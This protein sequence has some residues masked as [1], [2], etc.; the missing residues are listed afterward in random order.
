MEGENSMNLE[1]AM[2]NIKDLKRKE[3]EKLGKLVENKQV[4]E[5]KKLTELRHVD[6]KVI[7]KGYDFKELKKDIQETLIKRQN[8]RKGRKSTINKDEIKKQAVMD[9]ASETEKNIKEQTIIGAPAVS[10]SM[11]GSIHKNNYLYDGEIDDTASEFFPKLSDKIELNDSNGYYSKMELRARFYS[12]WGINYEEKILSILKNETNYRE[13]EKADKREILLKLK[14]EVEK[15]SKI[16]DEANAK[17]P[18]ELENIEKET[19]PSYGIVNNKAI[20][21]L[22]EF[23]YT[24]GGCTIIEKS[25]AKVVGNVNESLLTEAP[26][27]LEFDR[28]YDVYSYDDLDDYAKSNAFDSTE[29]ARKNEYERK[30]LELQDKI[31]ETTVPVF[32]K[33]GLEVIPPPE[34]GKSSWSDDSGCYSLDKGYLTRVDYMVTPESL[35]NYIKANNIPI[36]LEQNKISFAYVRV[37]LDRNFRYTFSFTVRFEGVTYSE[38]V[39]GYKDLQKEVELDLEGIV[40]KITRIEKQ[41]RQDIDDDFKNR[42]STDRKFKRR[43]YDSRG[44]IYRKKDHP[45]DK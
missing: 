28:G 24:E 16:I 43:E 34:G 37:A 44:N 15:A 11:S 40:N 17:I 42:L 25:K 10:Y 1:K 26:V 30:F 4:K 36:D 3:S 14:T 33:V 22:S 23:W 8:E 29:R 6:K 13:L 39:E 18:E 9:I 35:T 21:E 7:V 32:E 27:D 19:E 20:Q 12:D 2:S 38:E 41:F 5:T 31:F 45:E